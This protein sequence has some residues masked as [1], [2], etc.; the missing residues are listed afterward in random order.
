MIARVL[1]LL[2][3][4][5]TLSCGSCGRVVMER[6]VLVAACAL[7]PDKRDPILCEACALSAGVWE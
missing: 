1:R 5:R 2:R 4:R 3:R 7:P 6:G